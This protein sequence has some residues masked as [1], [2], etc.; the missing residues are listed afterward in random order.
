M[1]AI[2]EGVF[3]GCH[4]LARVIFPP[5]LESIGKDAFYECY[6]LTEIVLYVCS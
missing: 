5:H 6:S 3:K 4:N 2:D 1:T